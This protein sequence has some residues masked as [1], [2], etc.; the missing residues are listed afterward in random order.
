M[1][2]NSGVCYLP[3][4]SLYL[5]YK[6]SCKEK[7]NVAWR[8]RWPFFD[9]VLSVRQGNRLLSD[10]Y[11]EMLHFHHCPERGDD[12]PVVTDED[13]GGERLRSLHSSNLS[14]KDSFPHDTIAN[15]RQWGDLKQHR[16]VI[17]SL[18]SQTFENQGVNRAVFLLEALGENLFPCLF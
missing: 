6:C 16:F 17:L 11:L 9:W 5:P 10:V 12:L 3:S 1:R 14:Q 18:G 13:V 4:C 7:R 2:Q 15:H 8:G